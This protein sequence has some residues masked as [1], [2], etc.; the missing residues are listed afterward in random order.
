MLELYKTL[1]WQVVSGDMGWSYSD[2]KKTFKFHSGSWR[3][4]PVCLEG[5]TGYALKTGSGSGV[6]A[7]DVDDGELPHNQQLMKLCDDA[8]GIKQLTRKGTHYLFKADNR[9]RTTTSKKLALDI[10]NENALLYIEPSQYK[11]EGRTHFYK[12]ANLPNCPEN[13]PECPQSIVDFINNLYRPNL[14]SEQKKTIRDTTKRENSGMEKLRV[15]ISKSEED[16]RTAL[17]AINLEHAENYADWI[18]VGLALHHEGMSWELFDEFSRRSPKYKEGEPYYVYKSFE[19]RPTEEPVSLRTIYW[20]LKSENEPVF[21]TLINKEENEEYQAWKTEHEKRCCVIASRIMFR[22]S[23]GHFRVMTHGE[24]TIQFMNKTFRR[25]EDGKMKKENSYYW[26]MRDPARLEYERMDFIPPPAVCPKEVFNLWHGFEAESLEAVPDDEIM[27]LI[28]P[29]LDHMA[30]MCGGDPK[31]FIHWCANI[32]R[33]PGIKSEMSVVL[34]DI[35]Q[36]LKYGGGTGKNLF[37]DWFGIQVVGADYYAVI[38][39]N[40]ELFNP[41]NEH[42]EHKLLVYIAEAS[43]KDNAK[44]FDHL[45]E[46]ITGKERW[47]NRKGVPKYREVD[48]MRLLFG[49]NNPNPLGS[50]AGQPGDRRFTYYD[51]DT[52]KKGDATYFSTLTEAMKN[53]RVARAFY[54]Y[55]LGF[56]CYETPLEFEANRPWTKARVDLLRMNAEPILRWVIGRVE[57]EQGIV[58]EAKDLFKQFHEWMKERCEGMEIPISQSVFTRYLQGS[59][60]TK[61]TGE[62]GDRGVYKNNVN[63][64]ELNMDRVRSALVKERYI[65]PSATLADIWA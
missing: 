38:A 48:V 32:I 47:V 46:M 55:L 15:D 34:R 14:T 27:D 24:A 26:W 56:Q 31:W 59:A 54:Q 13:V 60:F 28:K 16:L 12:F 64:I 43:R 10:R 17:N 11:V 18:K 9:L 62:R 33:T 51:V 35:H 58:G 25:W 6:M 61:A 3:D 50:Q 37:M 4:D 57:A 8:G 41:F 45:K 23:N 65:Q 19:N 20:W 63:Y 2:G 39:N 42:L 29:I 30:V 52:S 1:G 5:K 44:D 7:I 40:A 22:E 53:S 36:F 21:R 49:T